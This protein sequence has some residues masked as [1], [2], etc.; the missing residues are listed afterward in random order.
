MEYRKK[1]KNYNNLGDCEDTKETM[2]AFKK[3]ARLFED[4]NTA[5]SFRFGR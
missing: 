4:Q 3:L 2:A 5:D 1:T